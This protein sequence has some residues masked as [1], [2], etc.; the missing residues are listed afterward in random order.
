MTIDLNRKVSQTRFAQMIGVTQPVISGLISRGIL[1]RDDSAANWLLSY[2]GHLR[3][4]AAGRATSDG[5][6]LAAERARLSAAQADKIEMELAV[7]RGELAQVGMLEQVLTQAGVKAGGILD[8]VPN[9]LMRRIPHLTAD[10]ID[11]VREEIAKAR[12]TV[13]KLTLEDLEEG[14]EKEEE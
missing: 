7:I 3:E 8:A 6:D 5:L 11:I 2:C 10:D 13:A 12:N 9:M 14:G 4:E 1:A